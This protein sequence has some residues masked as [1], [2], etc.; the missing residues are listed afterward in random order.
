MV[1]DVF[2]KDAQVAIVQ[3][4]F[5]ERFQL[6]AQ[7]ARHVTDFQHA[8]IRQAGFWAD[9]GELRHVNQD[10]ISGKLVGPGIDFREVMVEP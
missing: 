7:L 4:I 10:F 6:Q 8:K 5:L 1:D 3:Q 9:G 2:L